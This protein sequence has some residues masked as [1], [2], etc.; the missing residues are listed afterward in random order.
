MDELEFDEDLFDDEV[1]E[2]MK[3]L[4]EGTCTSHTFEMSSVNLR[5]L[6]RN[7]FEWLSMDILKEVMDKLTLAHE[8]AMFAAISLKTSSIL[9][10][11]GSLECPLA[12]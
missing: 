6:G 1:D 11:L 2:L 12:L 5:I 8:D 7:T 10:N 4:P 9:K 3:R